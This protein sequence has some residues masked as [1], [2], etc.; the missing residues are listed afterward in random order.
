[1]E[2][3]PSP[4]PKVFRVQTVDNMLYGGCAIAFICSMV[5]AFPAGILNGIFFPSQSYWSLGFLW[6]GFGA[7]ASFF[8][9]RKLYRDNHTQARIEILGNRISL[10]DAN[11]H[12]VVDDDIKSIARIFNSHQSIGNKGDYVDY[13]HILFTSG[14]LLT[15]NQY[16]E[17]NFTLEKLLK[18]RM[19]HDFDRISWD[20]YQAMEQETP[21]VRVERILNAPANPLL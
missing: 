9:I 7:I 13:F 21:A 16:L 8:A 15:F 10:Y 20:E 18:S 1:M 5:A 19:Q 4:T 12:I 17:N 6:I 3:V 14:N 2:G 11:G